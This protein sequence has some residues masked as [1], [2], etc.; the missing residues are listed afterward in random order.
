MEYSGEQ[1]LRKAFLN[2]LEEY[3]QK[4]NLEGVKSMCS[5]SFFGFGT[6]V[7]EVSFD[8]SKAMEL[9]QRDI[10]NV[11]TPIAYEI[12]DLHVQMISETVGIIGCLLNF[13]FFILREEVHL[14]GFRLTMV[15]Q[16]R[17]GKWYVVHMHIS[18]PTTAHGESEAY[19]VKEIEERNVVLERLLK[20]RTAEL[21]EANKELTQ[22][23]VTDKLTQ[24][25][26]RRY[27]EKVLESERD[28]SER[29]GHSFCL[30]LIDVDHFKE[31]NDV[32]GHSVGDRVLQ[33]LGGILTSLVRKPDVCGRWGGEE[34]LLI[35]PETSLKTGMRLA[36]RIR[37]EVEDFRF[38]MV[39]SKT[40]SIGVTVFREGDT[41]EALLDRVDRALYKAK[42]N[43]RNMVQSAE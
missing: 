24:L 19:P 23:A 42:H 32:F 12:H 38:D 33:Q 13:S 25:Y 37:Q 15:W 34:F 11:P 21:V 35:C 1:E 41:L 7:D 10:E 20:E 22:L 36:E 16:K 3:L 8:F 43:G 14:R 2:Y 29:Y 9:Y 4:R 17:E 30:L 26:N 28:R 5:P 40:V 6:G 39:G 27:L 31:V 18:L